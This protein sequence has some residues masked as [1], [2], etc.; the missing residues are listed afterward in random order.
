MKIA[1][2]VNGLRYMVTNEHREFIN[3]LKSN[4][5]VCRHD[6]SE[7]QQALAEELSRAGILNRIYNEESETVTYNIP[8]RQ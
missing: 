3:F 8:K 2:L 7:R 6:L 1:E 4:S 5:D